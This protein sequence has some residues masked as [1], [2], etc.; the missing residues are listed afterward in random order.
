MKNEQKDLKDQFQELCESA[1]RGRVYPP[2]LAEWY[3]LRWAAQYRLGYGYRA[4]T[5]E[6]LSL[7]TRIFQKGREGI[8]PEFR[9]SCTGESPFEVITAEI[10]CM[11]KIVQAIKSGCCDAWVLSIFHEWYLARIRPYLSFE[12]KEELT[13]PIVKQWKLEQKGNCLLPFLAYASS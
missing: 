2:H 4:E 9:D 1:C 3:A 7:L 10:N 12:F 11:E 13:A 6:I 8:D 5:R